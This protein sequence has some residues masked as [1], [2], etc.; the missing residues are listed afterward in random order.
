MANSVHDVMKDRMRD[1]LDEYFKNALAAYS[2]EVDDDLVA[3]IADEAF[4]VCGISEKE[5]GEEW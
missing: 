4:S 3:N 1:L 5:Q 2:G